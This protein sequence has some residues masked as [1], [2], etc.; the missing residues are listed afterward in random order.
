M[1]RETV[2]KMLK[3]FEGRGDNT[4]AFM[5]IEMTFDGMINVSK[6]GNA[7]DLISMSQIASHQCVNEISRLKVDD[8]PAERGTVAEQGRTS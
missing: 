6:S 5:V 3:Q 1:N 8:P 7:F 2:G 4:R